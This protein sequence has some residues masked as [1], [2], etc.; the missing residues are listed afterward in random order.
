MLSRA[1]IPLAVGM[2]AILLASCALAQ[3]FQDQANAYDNGGYGPAR[4]QGPDWRDDARQRQ[5]N[6]YDNGGYSQQRD[7]G[8]DWRDD[9]RQHEQSA[10]DTGKN[11]AGRDQGPDWS[12]DAH[13]RDRVDTVRVDARFADN[14]AG[15]RSQLDAGLAQGWLDHDDFLIFA[16]Q[17]HQTELREAREQRVYAGAVPERRSALIRAELDE[18][19]RQLDDTRRQR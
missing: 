13:R 15:I 7:Q 2:A 3:T 19:R 4:D 10:Y 18:L 17:L 12:D 6:A 5:E 8:P 14:E 11:S 16:R 9:G 1:S